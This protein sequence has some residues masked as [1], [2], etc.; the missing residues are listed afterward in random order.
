MKTPRFE[1]FSHA[2]LAYLRYLTP[3]ALHDWVI[4]KP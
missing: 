3:P 1:Q 4:F 2:V